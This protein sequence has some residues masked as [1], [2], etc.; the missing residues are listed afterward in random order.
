MDEKIS[1]FWQ[2]EQHVC[3]ACFGRVLSRAGNLGRRVYRCAC[4]G[5]EQEGRSVSVLCACGIK[6]RTGKGH[7]GQQDAGIRCVANR[8]RSPE[9]LSEVV[10]VAVDSPKT[11]RPMAAELVE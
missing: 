11:D 4:C 2:V 6:L 9:N 8:D 7:G 1:H 5:I 3:R 10:A